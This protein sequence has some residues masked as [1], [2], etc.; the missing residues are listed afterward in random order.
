ML[1]VSELFAPIQARCAHSK[2]TLGEMSE[3]APVYA[4]LSAARFEPYLVAA[5][6]DFDRAVRLY[7][8][9]NEVSGA[10]HAQLA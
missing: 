2:S 9:A 7:L 3:Q 4:L 1:G 8:W 6:H 10:M 5:G